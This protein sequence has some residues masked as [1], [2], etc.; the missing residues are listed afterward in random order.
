MKY[1]KNKEW[2]KRKPLHVIYIIIPWT[3]LLNVANE[4][5]SSHHAELYT[6]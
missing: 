6:V 4:V 5:F 2:C 3:M 1:V